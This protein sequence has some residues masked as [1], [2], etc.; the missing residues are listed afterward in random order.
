MNESN[1]MNA[2]HEKFAGVL[3]ARRQKDRRLWAFFRLSNGSLIFDEAVSDRRGGLSR[4]D[5]LHLVFFAE[6]DL[7]GLL[8]TARK[9]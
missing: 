2:S 6:F 9:K 5:A 4:L 7:I 3:C 1:P 8:A